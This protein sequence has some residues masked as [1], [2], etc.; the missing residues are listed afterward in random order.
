MCLLGDRDAYLFDLPVQKLI[1]RVDL[2]V[3]GG[4]GLIA[5]QLH[6]AHDVLGPEDLS[7]EQR[8]FVAAVGV[9]VVEA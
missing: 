9:R 6:D 4:A 7:V 3:R 1:V 2:G 5:E 8:H